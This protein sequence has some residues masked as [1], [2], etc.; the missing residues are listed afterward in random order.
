MPKIKSPI[1]AAAGMLISAIQ[2]EWRE[3]LGEP[4]AEFSEQVINRAHD[5]LQAAKNNNLSSVLD[6]LTVK[7]YLGE[8]WVRKHQSVI[9]SI[10]HL[11]ALI[12]EMKKL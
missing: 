7:Q 2:K 11:Q 8:I 12:N 1:E 3:E 4:Q 9:A 5:L 10:S 6:S